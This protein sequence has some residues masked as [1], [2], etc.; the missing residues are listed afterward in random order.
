MS[1]NI[2]A[3]AS[4]KH[5]VKNAVDGFVFLDNNEVTK[6]C[7]AFPYGIPLEIFNNSIN[8]TKPYPGDNGILFESVNS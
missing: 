1:F 4:C 3:C 8:H 5:I 7:S 2:T 6:K